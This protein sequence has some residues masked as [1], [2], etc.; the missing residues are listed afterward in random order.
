MRLFR[1]GASPLTS[2]LERANKENERPKHK[3]DE[4]GR[5][6]GQWSIKQCVYGVSAHWHTTDIKKNNEDKKNIIPDKKLKKLL[7]LKKKVQLTYF[8]LQKFMNVHYL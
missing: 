4:I 7:K 1:A 8:N 5:E 3:T 6:F 2:P